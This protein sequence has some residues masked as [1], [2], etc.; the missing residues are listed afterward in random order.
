MGIFGYFDNEEE[1][2]K[3]RDAWD[4]GLISEKNFGKDR[5]GYYHDEESIYDKDE[6]FEDDRF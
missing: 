5:F 4:R 1:K 2:Q 6:R 3:K